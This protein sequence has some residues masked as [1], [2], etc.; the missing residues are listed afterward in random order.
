[1]IVPYFVSGNGGGGLYGMG[2]PISGSQYRLGR[3]D[4]NVYGAMKVTATADSIRFEEYTI[5]NT[6]GTE[7]WSNGGTLRDGYTIGSGSP[8]PFPLTKYGTITPSLLSSLW[9]RS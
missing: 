1:V 5:I 8:P 6:S 7:T 3:G 4:G 9:I 2:S